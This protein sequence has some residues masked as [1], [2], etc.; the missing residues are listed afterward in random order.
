MSGDDGRQAAWAAARQQLVA[1][2]CYVDRIGP[3]W[4]VVFPRGWEAPARQVVEEF[5]Q[6]YPDQQ[7]EFRE[8]QPVLP[9]PPLPGKD[10]QPKPSDSVPPVPFSA[11][12]LLPEQL[13]PAALRGDLGGDVDDR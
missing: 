6:H 1:L 3:T 2:G 10:E 4:W 7:V 9:P 11:A 13:Y 5:K 12:P 8:K